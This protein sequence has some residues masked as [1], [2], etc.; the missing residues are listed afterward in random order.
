M[1]DTEDISEKGLATI[2]ALKDTSRITA[3]E[4]DKLKEMIFE[5]DG[6]LI[7]FLSSLEGEDLN[8]ELLNYVRGDAAD[9]AALDGMTSP[10]DGG[11]NAL[12]KKRKA[13]QAAKG[14][15]KQDQDLITAA[16]CDLGA[17]PVMSKGLGRK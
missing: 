7:S 11:L 1:V 3:D 9:D 10:E 12:K 17:S 14:A 5:E 2:S 6:V 15:A 13:Q 4:Y 16:D 8:T